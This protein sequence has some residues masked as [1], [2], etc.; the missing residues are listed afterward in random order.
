L[1][2]ARA[3]FN[4]VRTEQNV[5]WTQIDLGKV[6][7][8]QGNY[9]QAEQLYRQSLA[10]STARNNKPDMAHCL[11]GLG[12]LA[13]DRSEL[14][15]AEHHQREALALYQQFELEVRMAEVLS[16]LGQVMVA[17]DE[18]HYEEARQ[19]FR[20]ALELATKHQLAP[21]ALE[22]GVGV[23]RLRVQAGELEQAIELLTL[24]EQ[25]EASTFETRKRARQLLAE[26]MNQLPPETTQAAQARGQT[27]ELWAAAQ[28]LLAELAS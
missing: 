2:Q 8:L 14:R 19:F 25:H 28:A 16:Q 11:L 7:R 6:F 20:Q 13:Y 5:T 4:E 24:V 12:C 3:N 21:I 9:D 22:V 1:Q 27:Q 10:E 18:P 17:A 15:R 23:A 26:L